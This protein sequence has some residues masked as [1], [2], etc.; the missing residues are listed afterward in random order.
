LFVKIVPNYIGGRK[1]NEKKKAAL[2][3]GTGAAVGAGTSATIGGMGLT[4]AGTAVGIGAAP[5]AA[6]G[7]VIGLAG[8]GLYKA[9][10]G[11]SKKKK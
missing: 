10:G 6:A 3:A 2:A 9:F 11:G 8:Y 1:M 7:A 4:A 5:V